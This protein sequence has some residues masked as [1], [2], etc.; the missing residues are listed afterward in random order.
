[1]SSLIEEF[2]RKASKYCHKKKGLTYGKFKIDKNVN[3]TI[4]TKYYLD[5]KTETIWDVTQ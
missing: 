1:M 2:E 4:L 3:D 5:D